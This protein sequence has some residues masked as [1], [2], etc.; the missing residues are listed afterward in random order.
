[1]IL[2]SRRLRKPFFMSGSS[3]SRWPFTSSVVQH[4]KTWKGVPWYSCNGRVRRRRRLALLRIPSGW[5]R[6]PRRFGRTC[7]PGRT[8]LHSSD[9]SGVALVANGPS[10][11]GRPADA[12]GA[13]AR[14]GRIALE[15]AAN[16]CPLV[17][18]S[19]ANW[20]DRRCCAGG[21][22][23][24]PMPRNHGCRHTACHRHFGR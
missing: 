14:P 4:R 16:S 8:P 2:T 7:W 12:S 1:M 19:P 10:R 5:Q 22:P 11:P 3:P 18:S 24:P 20:L 13:A 9:S 17:C 21:A 15:V 23:A 6:S